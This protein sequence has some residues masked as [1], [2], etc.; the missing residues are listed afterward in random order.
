M[1]TLEDQVN[2]LRQ[3][4]VGSAQPVHRGRSSLF[5]ASAEAAGVDMQTVLDAAQNGLSTLSQ[6]DGRF[7]TY[8]DSLLHPS[9]VSLQ[10]ELKTKEENA[11][12]DKEIHGL[13]SLLSLFASELPAHKVL[14]YLVQ[15]YRVNEL[16]GDALLSCLLP[17]HDCKV[18]MGIDVS[19]TR[20]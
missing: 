8:S 16:N 3:R 12:L 2:L 13:L 5:M 11:A 15:R 9:S 4:N 1:T 7:G 6:Y 17:I 18:R 10:R 14:E 20:P 19:V